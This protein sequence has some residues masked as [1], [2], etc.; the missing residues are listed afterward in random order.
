MNK[1]IYVLIAVAIPVI[2]AS[3]KVNRNVPAREADASGFCIVTDS[4]PDAILEMRYYS[5]FNFIGKRID[6]YEQPT[7]LLTKE[8]AS[9]LRKVSEEVKRLGYRLKIFDAYRP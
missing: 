8:A 2:T 9:A 5:T 4:V 6:G 7:A 1:L 3:N